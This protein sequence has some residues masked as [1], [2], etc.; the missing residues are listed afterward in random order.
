[1]KLIQEI[2]SHNQFIV[3]IADNAD[4]IREAQILRY[5]M[6]LLEFDETKSEDGIDASEYDNFCDILI[7]KDTEANKIVGTYRLMTN[8]H[9]KYKNEFICEDEFDITN[10]KNSGY[11]IL[12]LGRA[13][14]DKNYRNGLIIKLLWEGIFY[15]SKLHKIKYMFG[16]ASFHGVDANAYKNSLSKIYYEQLAD[17]EILCYAKQPCDKLNFL[18]K[19]EI[20]DKKAH[21]E[22]PALV[23]G[24]FYLGCRVGDGIFFDYS[25]NSIDILIIFDLE[26][27]N[28]QYAKRFFGVDL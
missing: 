19:E 4:E 28:K 10:L 8:E 14:V 12:E 9:L 18:N 20:D 23:R 11:N 24:Y 7:V 3:G 13:V 26:N 5:K 15:Y 25:F 6:L 21:D 1:M 17:K 22:T 16:T 2:N 27:V